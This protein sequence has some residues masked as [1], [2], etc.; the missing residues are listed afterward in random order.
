MVS[1]VAAAAVMGKA[2]VAPP[3]IVT[4]VARTTVVRQRC[5]PAVD[6]KIASQCPQ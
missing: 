5:R 2:L 1:T 3:S 6:V 4:E